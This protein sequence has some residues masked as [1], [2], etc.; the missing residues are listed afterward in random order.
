MPVS[1]IRS[2]GLAPAMTRPARG[3]NRPSTWGR[4]SH[5]IRTK[6]GG[7]GG[8]TMIPVSAPKTG[9]SPRAPLAAFVSPLIA[10]TADDAMSL[11]KG[12]DAGLARREPAP[13]RACRSRAQPRP[14][15]ALS[16]GHRAPARRDRPVSPDRIPGNARPWHTLPPSCPWTRSSSCYSGDIASHRASSTRLRTAC[17][18][19]RWLSRA[20]TAQFSIAF[21]RNH[22]R[23]SRV[24]TG[25]E[26]LLQ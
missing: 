17:H 6:F 10:R 4:S 8:L 24:M 5:A 16:D 20:T 3:T 23:D 2:L 12:V 1:P 9:S 21:V 11:Y 26:R 25:P 22:G 7:L 15:P 14:S 13:T 19:P 18:R